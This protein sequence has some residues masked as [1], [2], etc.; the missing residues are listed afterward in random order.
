MSDTVK[1]WIDPKLVNPDKPDTTGVVAHELVAQAVCKWVDDNPDRQPDALIVVMHPAML[2]RLREEDLNFPDHRF[3][4][5]D[6]PDVIRRCRGIEHSLRSGLHVVTDIY[7][8]SQ[9]Y[10][11]VMEAID[12]GN[13]TQ[14]LCEL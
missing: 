3:H 10:L 9:E 4:A 13:A 8:P 11:G 1:A 6:L 7:A 14:V 12:L 2:L 5:P